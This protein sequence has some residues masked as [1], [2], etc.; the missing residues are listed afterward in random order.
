LI[1]ENLLALYSTDNI[2][3]RFSNNNST[4]STAVSYSTDLIYKHILGPSLAPAIP[5]GSSLEDLKDPGRTWSNVWG[6]RPAKQLSTVP[7]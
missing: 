6:N 2:N 1:E 4:F 7:M 5:K 3:K